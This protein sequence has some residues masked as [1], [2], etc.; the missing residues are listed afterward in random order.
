MHAE[1][2]GYSRDDVQSARVNAS[3][4]HPLSEAIEAC[5][6]SMD[7][8]SINDLVPKLAGVI[9]RGTGL[10]TRVGAARFIVSLAG[11]NGPALRA[12]APQLTK[13]L[14]ESMR[15]D[16][17]QAVRK[18]DVRGGLR[19]RPREG[20]CRVSQPASLSPL[21]L[22]HVQAVA[23]AHVLK[24]SSP[25]RLDKTLDDLMGPVLEPGSLEGGGGAVDARRLLGMSLAELS[26]VSMEAFAQLQAR[27]LPLA[28]LLKH[29]AEDPES[30]RLFGDVWE[31]GC[32]S[33]SAGLGL[34]M[35]EVLDLIVGDMGLGGS[36]WWRKRT[37]AKALSSAATKGK[38][39]RALIDRADGIAAQLLVEIPGRLFE[40]KE[41]YLDALGDLC[42]A[43][44]EQLAPRAAEVLT[45]LVGALQRRRK[46][47][48]AA[49]MRAWKK[50]VKGL[51]AKHDSLPVVVESV[52]LPACVVDATPEPSG[53]GSKQTAKQSGAKE[54]EEDEKKP[55]RPPLQEALEVLSAALLADP[56]SLATQGERIST[57]LS[58]LLARN[59]PWAT[60]VAALD[61]ARHLA[62]A[63]Y[64]LLSKA[65]V[66]RA[67][68][69]KLAPGALAS[70]EDLKIGQVRAAATNAL[71]ALV[72]AL[73]GD[74][75]SLG[76][77]NVRAMLVSGLGKAIELEK[78]IGL[79]VA[80]GELRDKL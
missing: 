65:P 9:R 75:G 21:Q 6:R 40:G 32:A 64:R 47:W 41:L 27:A 28:F 50:A 69:S 73:Q 79:R 78:E 61:S 55:P 58:G 44:P 63:S 10:T 19:C 68:L 14:I 35:R 30:A 4:A 72:G 34:Y 62:D 17:S 31:A 70:L 60:R 22:A 18:A 39:V 16:P 23:L 3:R 11:R 42:E 66:Y 53:D 67:W 49:T 57:E 20:S 76:D 59:L 51:A 80:L 2:A 26:K 37:A 36:S 1:K 52:L 74:E 43:L 77:D 71:K 56:A 7:E 24:F 25:S 46:D 48:V 5:A 8:A 45:A 38:A 54:D 15:M 29:D 33:E 12:P 13:A